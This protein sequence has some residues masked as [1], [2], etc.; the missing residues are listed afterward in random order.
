MPLQLVARQVRVVRRV[1]PV[2]AHRVGEVLERGGHVARADDAV[3]AG[4]DQLLELEL[5]HA[6]VQLP[7]EGG[8]EGGGEAAVRRR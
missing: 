5:G 8:G 3:L 6:R 7:G 4:E 1:D 2:V